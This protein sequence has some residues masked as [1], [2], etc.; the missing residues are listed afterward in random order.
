MGAEDRSPG[1]WL[2]SATGRRPPGIVPGRKAEPKLLRASSP[3]VPT[4]TALGVGGPSGQTGPYKASGKKL[5]VPILSD[6][7]VLGTYRESAL[8]T[9]LPEITQV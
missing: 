9:E 4:L 2:S 8:L 7:D 5:Q 1:V 3:W 6:T